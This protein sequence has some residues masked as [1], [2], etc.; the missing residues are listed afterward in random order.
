[1]SVMDADA[2]YIAV[3]IYGREFKFYR[4]ER[5]E[6]ML[7]D[8]IRIEQDFWENHVEKGILPEPDG[9]ELADSVIAEYYRKSNA[10][11][12]LLRGFDEKLL[13]RQELTE[14]I[15]RMET[16]KRRI[17][18]ELKLYLGEAETAENE[19]YRVSWKNVES[20]RVDA[21]RLKEEKPEIYQQYS[22]LSQYRRLTVKAA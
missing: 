1:M 8:L 13:R 21:K 4:I 2:W 7:S 9:S 18:Q 15:E 10:R 12:I 5:D 11:S 16:E 14:G 17:E 19:R 3:L 20:T 22:S 6:Q